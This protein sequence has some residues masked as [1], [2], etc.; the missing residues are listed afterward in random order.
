[1]S[2]DTSA[3]SNEE[4]CNKLDSHANMV[5]VGMHVYILN[6]IG[7]T[8][9]MSPFT[10][11]YDAMKNVPIVDAI[12]AYDC[13]LSGKT[14][15]LVFHNSLFVSSMTHNFIPPFILRETNKL[16]NEVPKIHSHDPDETTHSIWFPDSES[17]IA[18]SL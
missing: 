12:I 6:Y 1:M 9:E 14:Y 10:S 7:R 3:D 15:L 4:S 13:P 18:L 8:A 2:V 17:R 5:V 16:F 11:S